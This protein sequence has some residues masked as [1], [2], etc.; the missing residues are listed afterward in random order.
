MSDTA[1]RSGDQRRGSKPL[2]F[3][4]HLHADKRIADVI[5]NFI[6]SRSGG[7]VEVFQSSS[8]RA[9]GPKAGEDLTQQLME[10]LWRASVVILV[11]TSPSRDWSYCMWECGIAINP[12]SPRTRVIVLQSGE[13]YPALFANDLRI[14][15]RTPSAIQQFTNEFLTDPNFFPR[16]E[17]AITEFQ[18]RSQ[19]VEQAAQDF[20]DELQQVVPSK[21]EDEGVE[22]W[23]PYPY[24]RL[25]LSPQQVERIRRARDERLQTT[26]DAVL[27]G[28][29]VDSDGE[30]RRLFGRAKTMPLDTTFGEL[31]R[32]W[33]ERFPSS[34][35]AWLEALCG[36]IKDA[37]D[38]MFPTLVWQLM[39]GLDRMDGTWYAPVLNRVRVI[40]APQAAVESPQSVE[41]EF[42]IYFDKFELDEEGKQVKVGIPAV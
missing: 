3:I 36:Q 28:L 12:A 6:I 15:L 13:R 21:D 11:Y 25:Q 8:A 9:S 30:A 42:D 14:N 23:A 1:S 10:W 16:Y 17:Q 33:K 4:S 32:A 24:L 26:I 40:R 19:D 31:V 27:D 29:I 35:Q 39:R 37:V 22:D 34:D 2:L 5:R 20:Y 18:P 41:M 7:R 38:G